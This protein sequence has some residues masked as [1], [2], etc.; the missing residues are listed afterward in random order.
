M[1]V[2]NEKK[3]EQDLLTFINKRGGGGG[4]GIVFGTNRRVSR[5]KQ[6]IRFCTLWIRAEP[7]GPL[8]NLP[9]TATC[10]RLCT[11]VENTRVR[12]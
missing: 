2:M 11:R 10:A 6:A 7:D 4:E 3:E 5:E 12:A 1:G 9:P 8:K